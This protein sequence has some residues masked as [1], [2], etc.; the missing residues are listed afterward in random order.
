MVYVCVAMKWIHVNIDIKQKYRNIFRINTY[1]Y[2]NNGV[3]LSLKNEGIV[4]FAAP[5][6][7]LEY[8]MLSEVSDPERQVLHAFTSAWNPDS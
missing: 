2:I 8:L 1:K 4:P 3:L 7:N 5:W 6:M